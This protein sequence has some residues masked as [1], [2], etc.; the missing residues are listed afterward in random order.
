MTRILHMRGDVAGMLLFF[1]LFFIGLIEIVIAWKKLNGLS[2][3]GY[4]DRRAISLV[5]GI[6]FVASSCAWYFSRPGHF[7]YPDVEGAETLM[8]LVLGLVAA[9]IIQAA[10]SALNFRRRVSYSDYNPRSA[11]GGTRLTI[12]VDNSL[13]PAVFRQATGGAPAGKPVLLL[14]DYGSDGE[15]SAKLAEALSARGHPVLTFDLDGHGENPRGIDDPL[16][17]DLLEA[18]LQT[19]RKESSQEIVSILGIGLGG[20]LAVELAQRDPLI[21]QAIVLDPPAFESTGYP[22]VNSLRELG[23]LELTRAFLKPGA[24][25]KTG[26]RVGLA[27]LLESMPRPQPLSDTRLTVLGTE[28]TWLN[29]PEDLSGYLKLLG[30]EEPLL[31]DVNHT[32]MAFQR[33]TLDEID[34]ALKGSAGPTA[35]KA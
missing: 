35:T 32:S 31:L 10:A 15:S 1:I 9:L 20:T 6:L 5:I 34:K 14:H 3:T 28:K 7:A 2:V 18:A 4:P 19:L 29:S 23:P 13:I 8:L 11:S 21:E 17:K 26:K 24:R 30:G 25:S 27:R 33:I 16:M 12:T 22:A